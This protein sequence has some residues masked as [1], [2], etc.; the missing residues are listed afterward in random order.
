MRS[1]VIG[2]RAVNEDLSDSDGRRGG[3]LRRGYGC[4]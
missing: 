2:V 1:G 4:K 3:Q